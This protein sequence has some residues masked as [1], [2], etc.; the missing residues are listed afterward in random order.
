MAT[1]PSSSVPV[2]DSRNLHLADPSKIKKEFCFFVKTVQS[3][4]IRTL[5]D[6]LKEIVADTNIVFDERG[7]MVK[8][9]DD[10]QNAMAHVR[11]HRERFE[12]FICDGTHVC[13]IALLHLHRLLKTMGS[14]DILMMYMRRAARELLEIRIENNKKS[15]TA[16]YR[17]Y[18]LDLKKPRIEAQTPEFNQAI[19]IDSGEFN[20]IIRE[21]KDISSSIDIR[22]HATTLRF[23]SVRG[24]FADA[25]VYLGVS[26]DTGEA[27]AVA[28]AGVPD[29]DD[30]AAPAG[31]GG[32]IVQGIFDL[33]YLSTF[34]KCTPLSKKVLMYL[35][36]DYPLIVQYDVSN[37]GQIS[38]LLMM[39]DDNE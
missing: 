21:M 25:D 6:A 9:V 10:P 22:C 7:I 1:E 5:V 3:T 4:A 27:E 39:E 30:G 31:S 24:S 18:L 12:E 32:E 33:K 34:T 26:T 11:L 8:A 36:N 14:T 37:L 29:D 23:S 16:H 2:V 20:K 35:R 28:G 17:L 38:L 19:S 13:G 15:K